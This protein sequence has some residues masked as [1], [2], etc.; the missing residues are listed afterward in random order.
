MC[1]V[2]LGARVLVHQAVTQAMMRVITF[3]QVTP[4]SASL[5]RLEVSH[6]TSLER[7]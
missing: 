7:T 4:T 2:S 6:A 5:A 1:Y 3:T